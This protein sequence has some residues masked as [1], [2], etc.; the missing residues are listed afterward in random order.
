[1]SAGCA[2]SCDD[3][4]RCRPRLNPFPAEACGVPDDLAGP[5]SAGHAIFGAA[6][7]SRIV[8]PDSAS[9][10]PR[11]L[12]PRTPHRSQLSVF[13]DLRQA[14]RAPWVIDHIGC[15]PTAPA[16]AMCCAT[17]TS[18]PRAPRRSTTCWSARPAALPKVDE[19]T[20]APIHS[21]SVTL[22]SEAHHLIAGPRSRRRRR[23]PHQG[24]LAPPHAA[25]R[26]FLF[27][28]SAAP[29]RSAGCAAW[30][31]ARCRESGSGFQTGCAHRRRIIEWLCIRIVNLSVWPLHD[32]TSQGQPGPRP[33][34]FGLWSVT[35]RTT[36][37]AA[38]RST[39]WSF[40]TIR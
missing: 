5:T 24:L 21:R 13:E 1:M 34:E 16:R 26:P 11:I 17:R 4:R 22:S 3:G 10:G 40:I 6:G 18:G 14:S 7:S 25:R 23:G 37:S 30:R 38:A 33:A 39:R 31:S 12:D 8:R 15:P 27:H 9:T 2:T 35:P 29:R 28:V 19:A 20:G 36:N 32:A